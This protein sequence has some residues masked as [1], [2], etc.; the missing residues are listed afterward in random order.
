MVEWLG[1]RVHHRTVAANHHRVQLWAFHNEDSIPIWLIEA[2][3]D[4]FPAGQFAEKAVWRSVFLTKWHCADSTKNSL[5]QCC[6]LSD[7]AGW[8]NWVNKSV[9]KRE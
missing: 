5:F 9:Q 4:S 1:V 6:F 2:I 3:P 7:F 8:V